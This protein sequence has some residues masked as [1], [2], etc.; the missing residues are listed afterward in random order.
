MSKCITLDELWN[1]V[2]PAAAGFDP[3]TIAALPEPARRYFAHAI[4]PGAALASAVRLRMHGE[5]RLKR[6]W[7]F[8]AE[9][10]IR[11]DR[12][13]LWS[14]TV[15]MA[16]LSV[17]GYDRLIDGAGAMRWTVLGWIPIM[18]AEGADIARSAAGRLAAE[19]CWLPSALCAP[20]VE[21]TAT[22]DGRARAA[23]ELQGRRIE[24]GIE[25]GADG[26]PA[27]VSLAR[28]GDPDGVGFRDIAFGGLVDDERSFGGYTIPSRLRVGWNFGA[29]RFA[30]DG[31]FFR[32]TIDDAIFR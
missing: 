7:P 15:R 20:G 9:Q 31:E 22:E 28:W 21:W 18:T 2:A 10:V 30:S 17:R 3:R 12:G 32:V 29:A 6:W 1:S 26:R 23:L 11:A 24:L 25:I 13:M 5:I 8:E 4:A 19:L 27:S 16:G 14:A